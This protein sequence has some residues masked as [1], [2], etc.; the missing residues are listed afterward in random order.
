MDISKILCA[1]DLAE[2]CTALAQYANTMARHMN[3]RVLV[4]YTAPTLQQYVGFQVQPQTI[5]HFVEE[6]TMTAQVKMDE[7]VKR[8]FTDVEA[9][10]RVVAGY[11]SE[12]IINTAVA[13]N[14]DLILMRTHGRTG[15]DR[16]LFGSVAEKVVHKST[17]PVLTLRPEGGQGSD[18]A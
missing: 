8:N 15:L 9:E 11:A 5:S 13:E 12:E 7:F 16:F 17:I 6:I 14:C 3:A 2:D 1:V 10:G 18:K 4:L